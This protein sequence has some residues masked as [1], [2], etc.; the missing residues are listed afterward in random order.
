MSAMADYI[1]ERASI[2]SVMASSLGPEDPENNPEYADLPDAEFDII[3]QKFNAKREV[4]GFISIASLSW[5][6][7]KLPWLQ[8]IYNY[9]LQKS[10]KHYT[11]NPTKQEQFKKVL[12]K[13]NVGLLISERLMNMPPDIAPKLHMELPEDI[14]FTKK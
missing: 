8:T 12:E 10:D 5:S 7:K 11:Q 6:Y 13:K 2:G 1:L 9:A 4:Y 14:N 3:A